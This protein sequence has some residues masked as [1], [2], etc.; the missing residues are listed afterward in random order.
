MDPNDE[1]RLFGLC[2]LGLGYPELGY[3]SLA[4]VAAVRGPFGLKVERDLHFKPSKTLSTYA[5]EAREKG[6]IVA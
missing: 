2:D 6:R 4:E 5:G 1:D 3:I